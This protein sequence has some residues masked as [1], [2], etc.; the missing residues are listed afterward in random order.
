MAEQY[1]VFHFYLLD[2]FQRASE[3]NGFIAKALRKRETH[4]FDIFNAQLMESRPLTFAK[5]SLGKT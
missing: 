1:F 2:P 3:E 4:V 5:G